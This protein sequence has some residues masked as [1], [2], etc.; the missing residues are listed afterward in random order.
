MLSR[1]IGGTIGQTALFAMP[2][3]PAGVRLA[4][5]RLILPELAHAIGELTRK[6]GAPG[7]RESERS[8]RSDD[9]HDHGHSRH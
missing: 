6:S 5:Q 9:G 7:A 1:A 2:G 8:E 4:M 3:S